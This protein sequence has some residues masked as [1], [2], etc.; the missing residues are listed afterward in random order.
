VNGKL[1]DRWRQIEM[2]ASMP[3]QST[4][5]APVRRHSRL[6]ITSL[7]LALGFPFLLLII[8]VVMLIFSEQIENGAFVGFVTILA[9][10]IAAVA[11]HLT[12]VILGIAGVYKK[13]NRKLFPVLGI[14][15]NGLPLLLSA[16][17]CILFV[18]FLI[19][20]FPLGPK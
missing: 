2:T 15:F 14:V 6:G 1:F 13:E 16:T 7:L 5:T 10:S 8:F 12:G 11:V 19:H 9:A 18:A 3:I 20:P 17:A 4:P